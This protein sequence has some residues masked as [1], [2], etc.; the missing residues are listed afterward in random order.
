M[1][2][3]AL[4]FSMQVA[5][6]ETTR[7]IVIVSSSQTVTDISASD[8]RAI[9]LGRL[10]RW[11]GR[12]AILPIIPSRHAR[13]REAFIRRVVR[14]PELDYAQHWIGLI[15][16]GQAASAP[17]EAASTEQ[18]AAF[19]AGHADA[20]AIVADVPAEKGVRILT[21]DGMAPDSA[22]YPLR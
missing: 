3:I 20:I 9:Y 18:A 10:T 19:V 17:L 2:L 14:M 11:P 8:L 4:L 12:R 6:G 7:L 5:R 15:F 22:G 21:V 13:G 16:R 1:V